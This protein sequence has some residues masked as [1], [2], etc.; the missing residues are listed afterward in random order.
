MRAQIELLKKGEDSTA[1]RDALNK[2][3]SPFFS[4]SIVSSVSFYYGSYFLFD[5]LHV[6]L[7][8]TQLNSALGA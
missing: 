7:Q 2:V 6:F 1:S 8:L 3:C 4:P 5:F